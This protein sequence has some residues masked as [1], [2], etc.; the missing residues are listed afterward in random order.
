MSDLTSIVSGGEVT[1][2]L[3][4]KTLGADKLLVLSATLTTNK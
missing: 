3:A 2:V 4:G 1:D